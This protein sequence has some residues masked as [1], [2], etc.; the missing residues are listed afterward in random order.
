MRIEAGLI[1]FLVLVVILTFTGAFIPLVIGI[2]LSW[3]AGFGYQKFVVGR[4]LVPQKG[5]VIIT[6][7]SSGIGQAAAVHLA[8]KGFVIFAGVRFDFFL[9]FKNS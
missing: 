7:C 8:E 9:P 3:A 2:L 6:G 4:A 1:S 5:A